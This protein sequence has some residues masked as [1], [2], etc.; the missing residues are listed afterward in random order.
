MSRNQ[1]GT[2]PNALAQTLSAGHRRWWPWLIGGGIILVA[3]A[4]GV[5]LGVWQ[6]ERS[7]RLSV[8]ERALEMAQKGMFDQAEPLLDEAIGYF[9]DDVELARARVQVQSRAAK[10]PIDLLPAVLNW[11]RLDP[12]NPEPFR[13]ALQLHR[14][15]SQR[16]AALQ[17]ARRLLE[18]GPDD[19]SVRHTVVQLLL[20]TER[21]VE[22]EELCRAGLILHTS[23]PELRLL[24]AQTYHYQ[25]RTQELDQT[26]ESLLTTHP[27]YPKALLLHARR[28]CESKKYSEAIIP[29]RQVLADNTQRPLHQLSRNLLSQALVASGQAEEAARVVAEMNRHAEAELLQMESI[30][31][32]DNL[33]LQVRA[34]RALADVG[35][36]DEAL[37]RLKSVLDRE[38]LHSA[39]HE[40]LA[41]Y[42]SMRGQAER[43]AHHRQF[44]TRS[45]GK[46]PP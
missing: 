45:R 40:L 41:D 34:A 27:T 30:Y 14:T 44:V 18:L 13:L 1:N 37:A 12:N 39:S 2:A 24:L 43:A 11:C 21:F 28:L 4:A 23:D 32:P 33:D 36:D 31:Q 17:A 19:L 35:Q 7:A 3:V 8:R 10:S 42:Y 29:L 38:P 5:A 16:E 22:A 15:L 20:D 9:P 46:S 25:G 26:L 6:A